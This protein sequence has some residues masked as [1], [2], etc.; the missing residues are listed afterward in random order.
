MS[1]PLAGF[2]G[3][4]EAG[5]NG[6]KSWDFDQRSSS[7]FSPGNAPVVKDFQKKV[8]KDSAQIVSHRSAGSNLPSA[9]FVELPLSLGRS[10]PIPAVPV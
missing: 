7:F 2:C 8:S 10:K 4:A 3:Q 1:I 5:T 9:Q 6:Y